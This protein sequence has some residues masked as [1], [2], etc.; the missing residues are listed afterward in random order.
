MRSSQ[1]LNDDEWHSVIAERKNEMGSLYVDGYLQSNGSSRGSATSKHIDLKSPYYVGGLNKTVTQMSRSNTEGTDLSL[2][3]CIRDMRLNNV[4]L[5]GEHKV[6]SV[7]KCSSKVE[8]GIFFGE[9]LR[10][11][12]ILRPRFSVGRVFE[13]SMDVK[14][15]RNTGVLMSVHGKRDFVMLQMKDGVVSLSV[16]NGKGIITAKY[17]PVTPWSLCDG[18]WHS[19]KVIKNKNV[20]ILV[21][22]GHSTN[23]VSGKI[24]A[25]SA[26]TKHPLFLGTQ[27]RIGDRRGDP[28]T[29]KYVGCM[30]NVQINKEAVDL[31]YPI[32]VGNVDAGSCPT[33]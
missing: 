15:R 14:P 18:R 8:P 24:G 6:I 5:G 4:K 28:T 2:S 20:A 13:L 29:I 3:G 22:D 23:P 30:K 9:G 12:V 26:D 27:P 19:V 17:E 16:D 21:V 33:I 10:S 1:P 11:H 7:Q 32:F 25:T 31:A